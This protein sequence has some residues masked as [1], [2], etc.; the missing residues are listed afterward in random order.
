MEF[1]ASQLSII[2]FLVEEGIVN[3][4]GTKIEFHDRPFL[5]DPMRDWS[6]FQCYKKAAQ[7]IGMSVTMCLKSLYAAKYMGLS[8]IHT[9]PT[10]SDAV[11]FVTTKANKILQSNKCFEGIQSDNVERKQIGDR[12]L[13]YKG[14]I[15]KSGALS[16]TADII[17]QD[18]KD[19]SDQQKLKDFESRTI[20]SN[21][22][23]VWSLSN[24]SIDGAGIDLDWQE[25]DKKEWFVTCKDKHAHPMVWPES[26]D[27]KRSV[28][29]CSECKA[30]LSDD[31]RRHGEWVQ[32]GDP[33][34]KW[35]GY[36]MTAMFA[37]LIS[38]P[39]IIEQWG[40]GKNP[41]Y[42]NNFILGEPYSP[43]D[44]KI[45]RHVILDNWT[46]KN[47]VTGQ[48]FL[49]VDVGNIRHYILGSEKGVIEIGTFTGQAK[50]DELLDRYHPTTV[51]DAMPENTMSHHYKD[52]VD[53]FFICHLGRD[54][55]NNSVL[56][57][58]EDEK[59]GMVFADKHRAIDRLVD[60]LLSGK[61]LFSV[62]ADQ[63]FRTFVAQC[64]DL[65]RV[66]EVDA[67][68]VERYV[69]TSLT[70]DDH[71][72]FALLFYWMAKQ[73]AVSGAA[74]VISAGEAPKPVIQ[75]KE[76]FKLNIQEVLEHRE[77]Y[78]KQGGDN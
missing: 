60:E 43:G 25:S 65:R 21:Y 35:S 54:K 75:T 28:F 50:L 14:T 36:H 17:I 3:E 38:A 52:T 40:E 30:E 48:Y 15:S 29:V 46:P 64:G 24:P 26:I 63:A 33:K 68:G 74:S 49:G 5:Y 13:H 39:F 37:P 6:R 9:F 10:E 12:F 78:G 61:I 66:K 58:G 73:T 1:K 51:M 27:L 72:L 55:E 41:E 56:R 16:T 18:E 53:N 11:E 47:L 42:F 31:D 59:R 62:P 20:A 7:A 23:G 34:A 76:G 57:W 2:G 8:P 71:G 69:W 22:K 44:T 67:L 70:G 32:T 45:D 77:F 4:R 19:R